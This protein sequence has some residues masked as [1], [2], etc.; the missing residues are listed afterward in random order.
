MSNVAT[1]IA[2]DAKVSVVSNVVTESQM[3]A[4]RLKAHEAPP[5]KEEAKAEPEE[6]EE[7][8]ESPEKPESVEVAEVEEAQSEE[9]PAPT[10][11]ESAKVLSKIDLDALSEAELQELAA[12]TRSKALARFGELT[13]DKKALQSQVAHLQAQL[14][15]SQQKNP[16]L[17]SKPEIP[18]EIAALSKPE[19]IQAK[20]KQAEEVID[21][22]ERVLDN[23]EHLAST[24]VAISVDGRDYTKAQVK[25]YMRDARKVKEKYLPAQVAELQ[26]KAQRAALKTQYL[27]QAKKELEWVSGDDNDLRKEYEA[28]ANTPAMKK[29]RES[30]PEVEPELDYLVMHAINSIKGK[31]YYDMANAGTA[32]KPSLKVTPPAAVKSQAVGRNELESRQVKELEKKVKTNGSYEDLYALRIK[33]HSIKR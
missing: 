11:A 6:V 15:Q 18:K 13:S 5:A 9:A 29:I 17:E 24:D 20:F 10:E 7:A 26:T 14:N 4:A 19:E 25:E 21:W 3:M 33:Q 1:S 23:A 16:V 30:V 27:E 28:I 2:E 8:E 31:R 12:K 32:A 22:A